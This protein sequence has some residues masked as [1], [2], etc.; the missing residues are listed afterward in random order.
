MHIVLGGTGVAG[1][2]TVAVLARSGRQ[3]RSVSR[4]ASAGAEGVQA[5][6]ADLADRAAASRALAGGEVAYFTVALPYSAKTWERGFP[7]ILSA[8]VDGCLEH[9]VRLVYLDNVYAYG[10]VDGVMTEETPIRPTSRK[11]RLRAK[12]LDQLD[13]A[14]SRG[15]DVTIGRS[16][17]FYGPGAGTSAFNTF[18]LDAVAAGKPP[19]WFIDPGQPHS[20]TYTP[21]VGRALAVL[22]T[23]DRARGRTW[24]L[25]TGPALTGEELMAL[26]AGAGSRTRT[27]S[28]AT[29]R[30]GALFSTP[31]RETLEL[32]Y[33]YAAPYRFDSS[34]F[35]G[36]F[37]LSPTS[38]PEGIAASLD[39]AAAPA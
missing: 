37:G 12:L 15:L 24:H 10:S 28:K 38:Y 2:E 34:R 30:M 19:T 35:E 32:A 16:A 36:T 26:A 23:D 25:P 8:V 17:D 31:A 39:R 22:G 7:P 11:G 13:E 18:V 3:V 6:A 21:D 1:R 29:L 14:R 33:Q 20:L 9:R 4:S 5:F 27:M